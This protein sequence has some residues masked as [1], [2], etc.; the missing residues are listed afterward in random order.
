MIVATVTDPVEIGLDFI[1][2]HFEEPIW[3]RTI[4]T[5]TTEGRQVLVHSKEETLARFKQANWLDCRISAYAPNAIE[6]PSVIQRFQGI[7]KATPT[8][9][10]IM[11][12]LDRQT[13][14]TE[15]AH[16]RALA[17]TLRNIKEKLGANITAPTVL[18]SGN[19]YH[20]YLIMDSNGV[21]L[22]DQD[23]F[24]QL[25]REPSQQFLRFV[26]YYLS[27]GKS[28]KFHNTTVS[29][30]NCMLRIPSSHNSKCIKDN[31]QSEVKIIQRWNGHRPL[32]NYL[33]RDFRR[34]LINQK[35]QQLQIQHHTKKKNYPVNS[36]ISNSNSPT[37]PWIEKLLQTPLED[38]RKFAV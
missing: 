4:S 36:G 13:F 5:R 14:K 16:K 20:I 7:K 1:L 33:L 28:D 3:P 32:I 2:S 26:E 27:N 17:T 23:V 19:G 31:R 8:T 9:I 30:R 11:V 35:I 29:F 21:S 34:Y 22:D 38:G 6:N 24:T 15:T 18:W 10:I 12:D 37:I 25:C